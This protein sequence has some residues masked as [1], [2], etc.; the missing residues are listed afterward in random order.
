MKC[1]EQLSGDA[2]LSVCFVVFCLMIRRPPRSTLFPYTTLFR[3]VWRWWGDPAVFAQVCVCVCVCVS[4]S[5]LC[6]ELPTAHFSL[7][8]TIHGW[9]LAELFR[10]KKLTVL[11]RSS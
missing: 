7:A 1:E 9:E 3:S 4:C 5:S 6:V 11:A 2:V 10:S 8:A